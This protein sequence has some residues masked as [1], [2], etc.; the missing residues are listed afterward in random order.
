MNRCGYAIGETE[1]PIFNFHCF[2]FEK[3]SQGDQFF[4]CSSNVASILEMLR[5]V[6]QL[7]LT[8]DRGSVIGRLL[9]SLTTY[10]NYLNDKT[11][12]QCKQRQSER[13]PKMCTAK[14]SKGHRG[15]CARLN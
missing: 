11:A 3:T 8:N 15:K 6:S 13:W 2:V 14:L 10:L 1:C 5:D 4:H 7:L 12:I 9:A